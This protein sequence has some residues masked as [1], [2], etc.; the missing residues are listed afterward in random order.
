MNVQIILSQMLMLLAMMLVGYFVWKKEWLSEVTY[1]HLSKIVVNIFNPIL[2]I[3][4]VMGKSSGGTS[5][6]LLQ[7][8]GF[9]IFFYLFMIVFGIVLVLIIRPIKAQRKIYRLMTLFPNVGFMGIP[10]I[11]SIFG[12]ESM[13]YIVFYMLGYNLLLYTYGLLLAGKA[14]IDGDRKSVV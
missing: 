6:L 13:I 2:V 10:V 7:N 8:V 1:Q 14:A 4:G 9:V 3:Y 11:T 12:T 5:Q